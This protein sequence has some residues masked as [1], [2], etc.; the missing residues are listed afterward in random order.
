MLWLMAG[1]AWGSVSG[2]RVQH[3]SLAY[4]T[5][6]CTYVGCPSREKGGCLGQKMLHRQLLTLHSRGERRMLMVRDR[7]KS[8]NFFFI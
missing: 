3:S 7:E 4:T 8:D 2:F 5:C 1:T 6:C